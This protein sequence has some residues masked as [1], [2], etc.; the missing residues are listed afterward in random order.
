MGNALEQGSG[1]QECKGLL[2]FQVSIGGKEVEAYL[3]KATCESMHSQIPGTDSLID[4]YLQYQSM[5]DGIVLDKVSA[6]ARH[7]V[8]LMAR[9]L[10]IQPTTQA[11]AGL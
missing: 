7:P 4:F 9:D 10:Q 2:R 3:S 5:L 11:W 6:G 1:F 8:V